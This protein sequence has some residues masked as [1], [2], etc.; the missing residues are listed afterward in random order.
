[1]TANYDDIL[2][3][4]CHGCGLAAYLDQA[5]HQQGW[6]DS[7]ATRQRA[8]RYNEEALAEKNR[9]KSPAVRLDPSPQL[10]APV[11]ARAAFTGLKATDR[12]TGSLALTNSIPG[13]SS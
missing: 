7:V 10:P 9:R 8:Y 1:M 4:L 2:D 6:P 11:A 13:G 3:G 5:E 12:I